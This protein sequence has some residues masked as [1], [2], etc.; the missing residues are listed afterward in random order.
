MDVF[1]P[2]FPCVL[3]LVCIT[4][5]G[6]CSTNPATGE[7]QFT[8]LM[9]PAQEVQVG[10]SEHQKIVQQF[11]L[12]NNQRVAS[13]VSEI[14]R[15][16]TQNT[17]RPDVQYKFF[18][19]DSPIVNAFALPG[20]YI[21]VSRGLLALANSEAELA[22]V[23]AH[24]AGH[25]TARH[26]AE[27]Y[28]HGVVT[29]LGAAVLSAALDSS[30]ANQALGLGSNLYMSSYS[31]GQENQADTLGLRY[32]SNA[33][34]NPVSMSSFLQSLSRHSQLESQG[35]EN[36]N[37]ASSYFS[38][39]PA[40]DDRVQKTRAEAGQF[41]PDGEINREAYLQN[42]SGL[43]YGDSAKQGFIRGQSFYHTDLGFG[44]DVPPGF[45]LINQPSQ[46]VATSSNGGVIV[47]DLAPSQG[48][49]D[50]G[51]Y[52]QSVWMK[53]EGVSGFE[54]LTINGR[55]AATGAFP[56]SVN[57]Q[58]VTIRLVAIEWQ[59]GQFARFQMAIPGQG[60]AALVEQLKAATYSFRALSTEEKAR[61]RP[62]RVQIVKAGA[63]DNVQSLASRLPFGDL[64]EMTFRV[65]NALPA[66]AGL[67]AGNSYKL[68]T[69]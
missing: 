18:V 52:L 30:A 45:R 29:S 2:L 41:R 54:Y 55:K 48:V 4:V 6:G 9:S 56:G 19:L 46:V 37:Q 32:L 44:F 57:G 21:Y 5:L 38:T 43:T 40:T 7:S 62:Y 10:A 69:E 67:T 63:G 28:S 14:G 20:G 11:G 51:Q 34:Y 17:E 47:F 58:P 3:A 50:P 68:I 49:A 53:G 22:A 16:V 31:R 66:G 61:Y 23:L 12:Y 65:L 35:S 39:H 42:I 25:I 33:G 15:R 59:N 24:E 60:N 26:S 36:R 8:A 64:N 13:Y 27:R 1:K